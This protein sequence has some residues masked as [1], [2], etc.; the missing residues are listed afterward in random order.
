MQVILR[1]RLENLGN[2]GDVVQVKPGFARNYLIPQGLA[3]EA[4]SGNVKR[5][6]RERAQVAARAEEQLGAARQQAGKLEGVSV[7]F[8]ARAG[9]EGKLFGSITSGDIAEKLAEQGIE[10]DRKQIQLDEPLK[11]LGV[12][13]I[14]VRL[15]ADVRPE[16]KVWVI[17]ED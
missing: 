10:I 2:A 9:E 17:K 14:P 6:E 15:H 11:A 5:M 16:I 4:T 7:T 12:F 13:S 1:D 3:Y 8:N